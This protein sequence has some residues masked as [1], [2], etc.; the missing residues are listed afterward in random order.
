MSGIDGTIE[1]A[2]TEHVGGLTADTVT[3]GDARIKRLVY[4]PGWRWKNDMHPVVGSTLCMHAHVGFL[5]EGAI[6]IEYGDGCRVDFRAPAAVV[7][8]PGHDGWV[9]GDVPAVMIQV[10][11]ATVTV[12][13]FGLAGKHVHS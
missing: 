12:E 3:A 8:E 7:I 13:R 9:V 6:A 4:P 2:V 10:D 11:C 1:G 5:A